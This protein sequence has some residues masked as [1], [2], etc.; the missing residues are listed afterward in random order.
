ML[1]FLSSNIRFPSLD[2]YYNLWNDYRGIALIFN[3]ESFKNGYS[4]RNGTRKDGNDLKNVL[5]KLQF[6]VR[7]H[8][9]LK[10]NEIKSILSEGESLLKKYE[11]CFN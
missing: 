2:E 10:F 7:Q 1:F 5:Q 3:H 9:D 11:H 4:K 6:D 8:M